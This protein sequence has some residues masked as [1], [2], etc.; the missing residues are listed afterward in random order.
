[1]ST[2][3]QIRV[4]DIFKGMIIFLEDYSNGRCPLPKLASELGSAIDELSTI[5]NTHV[6]RLR[7]EWVTIDV[8]NSEALEE[9]KLTPRPDDV[10]YVNEAIN[11]LRKFITQALDKG[12]T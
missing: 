1:M 3:E 11:N 10:I 12:S 7:K 4:E 5:D 8:A 6:D 2:Q 9:N